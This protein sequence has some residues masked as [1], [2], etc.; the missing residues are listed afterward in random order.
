MAKTSATAQTYNDT[1][2]IGQILSIGSTRNTGQFFA[3]IGGLNGVRRVKSQS[4]DMGSYYSLDNAA[5][6]VISENTSLSAGTPRFYARTTKQN[7]VQISKYDIAVSDLREDATQQVVATEHLGDLVETSE[8]DRAAS[9][10]MDQMRADWEFT[11]LQGTYVA[12]SA[13]GTNVASGGLLDST[14]GIST[15]TVNASS[16]ALDITM[17]EELLE[18]M[19]ESG[20]PMVNPAIVTPPGYL[21]DISNL[22]GFAPQD[23]NVGG[24]AI[25]QVYS[26]F[27]EIGVIWTNAAKANNIIICDLAFCRPVVMPYKGGTDIRMKEYEDGASAQKGYIEGRIGVDFFHESYHGKIYGIA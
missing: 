13:V 12:R 6:T 18:T 8:F 24:V 19:A 11:C 9:N 27:G 17:I 22:Y 16:A 10:S 20:A 7:V 3:A 23:R 1:N 14:I 26:D 4:F 2:V 21:N 25:K 5:Q 15:N